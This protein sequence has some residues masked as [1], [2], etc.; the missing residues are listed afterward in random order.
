MYKS[1]Q[2]KLRKPMHYIKYEMIIKE[3]KSQ[4]KKSTINFK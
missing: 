2:P 3:K 4:R 1:A